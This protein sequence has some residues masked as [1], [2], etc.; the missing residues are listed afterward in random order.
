MLAAGKR[1]ADLLVFSSVQVQLSLVSS[2]Q[3]TVQ[4]KHNSVPDSQITEL[5]RVV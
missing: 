2:Q 5:A 3:L 1:E 4:N